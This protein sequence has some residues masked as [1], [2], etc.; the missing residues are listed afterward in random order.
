VREVIENER[1]GLL[2]SFFDTTGI[3]D[4]VI[5]VLADRDRYA[6]LRAN[7]RRTVLDRYD[8]EGICL[9]SMMA[10]IQG[11]QAQPA[12]SLTPYAQAV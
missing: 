7:A 9:P 1:N 4:R 8:L 5:E 11:G 12:R 3:A 2:V 10:L 6:T